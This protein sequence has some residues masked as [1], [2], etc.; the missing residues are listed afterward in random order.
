M[1]GEASEQGGI[2][3]VFAAGGQSTIN[4]A[5]GTSASTALWA[6]LMALA[7]Q[8]AHHGLGLVNP[9]I[10]RIAAAVAATRPF[11]TS[12]PVTT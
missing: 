11:T 9:A 7:D 8:E 6:G 2:P 5:P 12:L 3:I 10:Y 1:A 4:Q